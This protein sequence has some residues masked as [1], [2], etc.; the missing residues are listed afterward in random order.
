MEAT[1]MTMIK[2]RGRMK[3]KNE[4]VFWNNKYKSNFNGARMRESGEDGKLRCDGRRLRRRGRR[5]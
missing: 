3:K 2:L 5:R 4:K 1:K